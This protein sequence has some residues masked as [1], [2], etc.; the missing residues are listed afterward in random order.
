VAVYLLERPS[1]ALLSAFAAGTS[2][3]DAQ[4][5]LALLPS[6][7]VGLY[8][9][10]AVATFAVFKWRPFV[11]GLVLL[12]LSQ[13]VVFGALHVVVR[14]AGLV[15]HVRDVRAWALGAPILLIAAM[16]AYDRPRR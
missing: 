7:Q 4:G 13:L 6:F 16:V 11:T 1:A 8:V 14:Y 5:A 15:P 9:A 2:L 10:L 12:G 3:V